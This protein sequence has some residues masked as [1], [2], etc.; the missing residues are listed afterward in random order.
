MN[1]TLL[2]ISMVV[3]C[4]AVSAEAQYSYSNRSGPIRRA[5]LTGRRH[6]PTRRVA[7]RAPSSRGPITRGPIQG[8]ALSPINRPSATFYERTIYNKDFSA[9]YPQPEYN[10]GRW[11]GGWL[12]TQPYTGNWYKGATWNT[13]PFTRGAGR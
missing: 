9:A 3:L 6:S 2:I 12:G 7:S 4:G 13:D 1:K 10:L 8:R 5:P 11:G